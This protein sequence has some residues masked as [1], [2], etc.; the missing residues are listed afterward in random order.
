MRQ[1]EI[2]HLLEDP[3]K[4]HERIIQMTQPTQPA[5]VYKDYTGKQ[6]SL[7]SVA[8]NG[9]EPPLFS[10]EQIDVVA[11]AL[12]GLRLEFQEMIDDATAQLRAME[13]RVAVLEGQLS[14]MMNLINTIVGNG[15]SIE[16]SEM[17]KTT[18]RVKRTT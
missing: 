9:D 16:A 18:R 7:P 4:N 12:A 2:E 14:V 1:D 13:Q 6:P 17:T 3:I 11:Q 15:K 10:D 5:V 8:D